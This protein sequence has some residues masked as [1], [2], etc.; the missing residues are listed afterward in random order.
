M[1]NILISFSKKD[2]ILGFRYALFLGAVDDHVPGSISADWIIIDSRRSCFASLEKYQLF[3]VGYPSQNR[4]EPT[5][6]AAEE[7]ELHIHPYLPPVRMDCGAPHKVF[8]APR[9]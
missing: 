6:K 5:H 8:A 1:C 2:K 7:R 3:K 9:T 4:F